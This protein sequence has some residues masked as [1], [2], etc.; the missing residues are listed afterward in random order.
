MKSPS[1]VKKPSAA[2]P[3][4]A[5]PQFLRTPSS[6]LFPQQAEA[7]P[8]VRDDALYAAGKTFGYNFNDRW[9]LDRPKIINGVQLC[10][11]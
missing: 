4:P 11:H 5:P 9:W 8:P 2:G 10:A 6:L 1:K 7:V 3:A